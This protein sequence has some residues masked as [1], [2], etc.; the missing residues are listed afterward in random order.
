MRVPCDWLSWIVSLWIIYSSG[1]NQTLS[2]RLKGCFKYYIYCCMWRSF[3]PSKLFR[4]L[5]W[6]LQCCSFNIA[7]TPVFSS[8]AVDLLHE[9]M[10]V[11][12]SQWSLP[13]VG[14]R[15]ALPFLTKRLTAQNLCSCRRWVMGCCAAKVQL[16]LSLDVWRHRAD[17]HNTGDWGGSSSPLTECCTPRGSKHIWIIRHY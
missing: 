17:R 13:H 3:G 5:T 2:C 12:N 7:E 16:I 14:V 9:L 4:W 15:A 8:S 11:I 1:L 6:Y 10:L